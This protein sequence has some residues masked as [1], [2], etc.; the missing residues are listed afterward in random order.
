MFGYLE[1]YKSKDFYAENKIIDFYILNENKTIKYEYEIF[2]VF[3]TEVYKKDS[4][5]YYNYTNFNNNDCF[6]KFISKVKELS[7]YKINVNLEYGD[8]F[9]T[10][11]T[12]EYST[13]NGRLVV[14]AK[15]IS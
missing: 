6:K 7:L 3:K 15:K 5:K 10:L 13:K 8:K 1:K 2:A 12:C 14:I 4:F 11:S 9:I